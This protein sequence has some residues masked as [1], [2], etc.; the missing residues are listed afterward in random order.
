[1][2]IIFEIKISLGK[3]QK[4]LVSVSPMLYYPGQSMQGAISLIPWFI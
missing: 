2:L 1:M 3:Y 4:I